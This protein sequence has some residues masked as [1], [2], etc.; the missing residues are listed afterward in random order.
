MGCWVV[1][2]DVRLTY[3]SGELTEVLGWSVFC[4][5]SRHHVW[6]VEV[7]PVPAGLCAMPQNTGLRS[8]PFRTSGSKGGS[9]F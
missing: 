1:L 4:G 8:L 3:I 6:R 7:C 5:G 2:R 9:Q